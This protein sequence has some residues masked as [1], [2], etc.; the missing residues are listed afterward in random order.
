MFFSQRKGLTQGTKPLQLESIDQ[1]LKSCLWSCFHEIYLNTYEGVPNYPYNHL[2]RV[3]GSNLEVFFVRAW[4]SFF[5]RPTDSMPDDIDKA[6]NVVRQDFFEG[7]WHRVYDF[8]EFVLEVVPDAIEEKLRASWNAMLQ[9]ENSG[10]RI[11]GR[12]IV[13][14]TNEAELAEI[15]TATTSST[16]GAQQHLR[17]ALELFSNRKAPDYRNSI[18]ESICAIESIC[19]TLTGNPNATL[20]AALNVLQS[21]IGLHGALKAALSSLY[22]YT[23]DEHGIRHAMLEEPNLTSADAK[24]MLVACSA[25]TNYIISK[26]AEAQL[27]I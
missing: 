2:P 10:Y 17:T 24:F 15:E 27:R 14:V 5:K 8:I 12:R 6:I 3:R 11:L 16:E 23:S 18:K 7:K 26:A 25:F 13:E 21:K 19:R 20:G 9:R 1:E 4:L 22:G